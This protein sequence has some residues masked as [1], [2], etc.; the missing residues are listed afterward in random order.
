MARLSYVH[1]ASDQPF[2]GDTI[3]VYFDRMVYGEELCAW[4]RLRDGESA[5]DEE[6]RSFCEGR[7]A[8]YKVPRYIKFV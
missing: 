3:G 7:I 4:V 5:T 2:I 8:H 1:G 6:I